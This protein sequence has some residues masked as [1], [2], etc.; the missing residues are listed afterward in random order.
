MKEVSERLRAVEVR[1]AVLL[2]HPVFHAGERLTFLL[3]C[4]DAEAHAWKFVD[5][6]PYEFRTRAL[7][8]SAVDA[9]T[10]GLLS[11]VQGPPLP[12]GKCL[13]TSRPATLPSSASLWTSA[14]GRFF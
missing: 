10:T 8:P 7:D 14:H 2:K 1:S 13:H 6:N 3:I 9:L 12:P 4:T 5:G 11:W